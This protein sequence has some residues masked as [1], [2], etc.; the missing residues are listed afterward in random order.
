M[1]IEQAMHDACRTVGIVPPKRV[2]PGRW[3]PTPVEGKGRGNGSG[4]V[5]LFEDGRGGVA[6]NWVTGASVT[7]RADG[8]ERLNSTAPR[9]HQRR[10]EI[11]RRL[12]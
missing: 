3:V 1:S 8:A 2:A 5:R 9:R 6:W 4:R 12:E 10:D 11:A 7:F